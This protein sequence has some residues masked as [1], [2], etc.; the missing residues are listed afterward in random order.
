MVAGRRVMLF[1]L[2]IAVLAVAAPLTVPARALVTGQSAVT[3]ESETSSAEPSAEATGALSATIVDPTG[4]VIPGA[5]VTLTSQSVTGA[6]AVTATSD[7]QGMLL[8]SNLQPGDY[9]VDVRAK[10]FGA[11][12]RTHVTIRAGHVQ[13]LTMK[14]P[15]EIQ[16]QQ[17]KVNGDELDSNP[18]S[19][20]SAIV[21]KGSDLDA[22]PDD[23]QELQ[24]QL[25][26]IAGANPEG[27]AQFYVDGFSGGRLPPKAEIKEIRIEPES[28]FRAV[29][30]DGLG[31]GGDH[32][33]GR[34]GPMAR[35]PVYAGE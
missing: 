2:V 8:V 25:Q 21:L 19:N 29:R 15:I 17:V 34:Y 20:G 32:H 14:L 10:G 24:E 11:V 28:L 22:L 12:K 33:Q 7:S 30:R 31:T 26:A 13:R 18:D 5:E 23:P 16:E 9:A 35:Q 27:G 3:A 6:P 1:V 4:A